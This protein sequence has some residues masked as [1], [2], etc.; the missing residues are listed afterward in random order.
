M[1]KQ[2]KLLIGISVCF[3]IIFGIC[4]QYYR[5]NSGVPRNYKTEKYSMEE[6]IKLDD[7]EIKIN[8]FYKDV[9]KS[10]E[11]QSIYTIDLTIKN[12]CNEEKN[13][14]ELLFNSK[15]LQ[16]D[17]II[18]V[19]ENI[20]ENINNCIIKSQEEKRM[21]INY[22]FPLGEEKDKAEFYFPKEF[23]KNEIKSYLKDL[24][25]CEKYVELMI[26]K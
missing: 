22:S 5:I 11:L 21:Q 1:K 13:V 6:V 9:N 3:I 26:K 12:V 4:Y 23:Y 20:K 19:S 16:G 14:R 25:M 18:E 24:K 10:N 15:L 7:L 8:D 17:C 2:T